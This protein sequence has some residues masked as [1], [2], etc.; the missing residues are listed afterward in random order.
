MA[1]WAK[2]AIK[3]ALIIGIMAGIFAIF[4]NIQIPVIDYSTFSQGLSVGLAVLYHWFPIT[5]VLFPLVVAL[6]GIAVGI[7]TFK[8]G[9]IA[10]KWL[11]KVNE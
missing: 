10:V 11:M 6:A 1:D 8:Y 5:Q 7:L 3:T 2:I 9:M 4:A